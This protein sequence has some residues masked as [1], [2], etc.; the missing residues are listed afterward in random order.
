MTKNNTPIDPSVGDIVRMMEEVTAD[1]I[2][3]MIEVLKHELSTSDRRR[4][5]SFPDH[6]QRTA[7][8]SMIVS[9]RWEKLTNA[10]TPI[11]TLVQDCFNVFWEARWCFDNK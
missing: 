3:Q 11:K 8:I 10:K 5:E 9:C 4:F 7:A 1:A 2:P 6:A